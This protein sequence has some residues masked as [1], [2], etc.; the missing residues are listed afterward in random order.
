MADAL[1]NVMSRELSHGQFYPLIYP[2]AASF[3]SFGRPR[4]PPHKICE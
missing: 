2:V 3:D 1:Q 4:G